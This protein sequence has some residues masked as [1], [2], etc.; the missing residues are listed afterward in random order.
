MEF[1]LKFAVIVIVSLSCLVHVDDGR[2]HSRKRPKHDGDH[3]YETSGSPTGDHNYGQAVVPPVGAP[4]PPLAPC[5][6]PPPPPVCPLPD[7]FKRQKCP[8]DSHPGAV[9]PA[10]PGSP[11][12]AEAKRA[13]ANFN[14]YLMHLCSNPL[15]ATAA[16][17]KVNKNTVSKIL[18]QLLGPSPNNQ[19]QKP[20]HRGRKPA[21]VEEF[22]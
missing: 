15:E 11:L 9:S 22:E 18:I 10:G 4:P 19:Q 3:V 17:T 2:K 1:S 6:P 5:P 16:A 14:L 8:T 21:P 12:P 7:P 13:V 20:C